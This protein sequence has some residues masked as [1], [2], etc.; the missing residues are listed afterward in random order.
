[1]RKLL[2]LLSAVAATAIGVTA[3]AARQLQGGESF[4]S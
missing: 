1:M 2:T 4:E 3:P